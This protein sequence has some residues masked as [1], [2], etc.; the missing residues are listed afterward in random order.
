MSRS[1]LEG[2]RRDLIELLG[3]IFS[4]CLCLLPCFLMCSEQMGWG[5]RFLI[6]VSVVILCMLFLVIMAIVLCWR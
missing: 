6:V 1:A 4:I 5:K 2:T 3:L